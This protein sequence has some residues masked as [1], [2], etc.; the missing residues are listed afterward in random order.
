[1]QE[2]D[3]FPYPRKLNIFLCDTRGRTNGPT[4][5]ALKITF[6]KHFAN[7]LKT[8]GRYDFDVEIQYKERGTNMN[9]NDKQFM[10]QKIRTKYMEKQVTELD[11]LRKFDKKVRRPAG[12]FAYIFGSIGALVMGSGMSIVMTEVESVFGF[13]NPMIPGI[14]LGIVGM[15]IAIINYPIYKGILGS[16]RKKYAGKILE[17]SDKIIENQ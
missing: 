12:V 8:L 7:K 15:L 4:S 5:C 2:N 3:P 17:L 10:A 14:V 9:P 11:E 16:R 13:A 1:M 6:P